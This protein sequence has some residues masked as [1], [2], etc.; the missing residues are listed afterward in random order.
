MFV[1]YEIWGV[2]DGR[3]ELIECVPTLKEAETLAEN[4]R[5]F[6]DEVFILKDEDGSDPVEV[7]RLSGL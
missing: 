5:E 7:K 3:D 2:L 6:N 1:Q 4:E